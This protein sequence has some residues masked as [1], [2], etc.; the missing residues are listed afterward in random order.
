[1]RKLEELG[2][3]RVCVADIEHVAPVYQACEHTVNFADAS[4]E[5]LSH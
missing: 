5:F 1:M 2:G 4:T 3:D